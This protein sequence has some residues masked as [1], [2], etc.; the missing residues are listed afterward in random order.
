MVSISTS[1]V[2]SS[3][4]EELE[5]ASEC[6]PKVD[7][8]E[9]SDITVRERLKIC[10]KPRYDLRKVKNKGAIL[11]L[12]WNFLVTSVFYYVSRLTPESYNYCNI[13][14]QL[15]LIPVGIFLTLAGWLADI[16]FGRYNVIYWSSLIMWIS[17]VFLV[18]SMILLQVLNLNY[19]QIFVLIF[20]STLGIGCSGFQANIIQFGIDQLTDASTDEIISFVNWYAWTYVTSGV[21]SIFVSSCMSPLYSLIPPLLLC[22]CASIVVCLFM[23]CNHVLVKEP[24]INNPFKFIFHVTK[25]A[26]KTKHPQRRSAFTY[27]EDDM[28]SRLD[29][30]KRKYGGP[31]TTEQVEDVKMFFKLLGIIII[32]GGVFGMTDEKTFKLHSLVQPA[33]NVTSFRQCSLR[34]IFTETYYIT[35]A[36]L[37]PVNELII[38]PLFHRCLPLFGCFARVLLGV[39]LHIGR[40]SVL[41]ALDFAD[42][43]YA[44]IFTI[45]QCPHHGDTVDSNI[46]MLSAIPDIVSAV[47]YI[48]IL[49]GTIEVLCAQ[50][51]YSMKGVVVGIF[52]GSLILFLLINSRISQLFEINPS[53]WNSEAI[54]SC[55]F[56]YLLIKVSFL[57]IAAIGVLFVIVCFKKR[58]REHVLPNEQIF[59]ERYYSK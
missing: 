3:S 42:R 36:I 59:A 57:L 40:Y 11:V 6:K 24:V 4:E 56:W 14:F 46:Y 12:I 17:T 15:I 18:L 53:A 9:D 20:L 50:V 21:V 35:V 43:K 58:K 47:S 55:R 31:F 29:F 49:V 5:D 26:M 32:V 28:P 41:V 7:L 2:V 19:I 33:H 44:Y 1:C 13:C 27:C 30:G 34:Y 39:V 16:Q 54:V 10:F 23:L 51:P 48:F 52:Y 37:I 22:V 25:Y 38:H 45:I 8:L